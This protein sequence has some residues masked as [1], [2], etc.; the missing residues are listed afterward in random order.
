MKN[1]WLYLGVFLL[2]GAVVAGCRRAPKTVV[3]PCG[4]CGAA[5]TAAYSAPI[6]DNQFVSPAPNY[7]GV[8]LQTAPIGTTAPA[9]MVGS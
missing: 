1:G 7:D 8:P 3:A 6:Y 4:T 5:P 9:P 2:A